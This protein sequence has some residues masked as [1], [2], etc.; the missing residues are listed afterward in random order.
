ML[1]EVGFYWLQSHDVTYCVTCRVKEFKTEV[2]S[3]QNSM[4]ETQIPNIMICF[5]HISI[6]GSI[7]MKQKLEFNVSVSTNQMVFIH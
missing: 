1:S 4:L 5:I 7:Y 3:G 2:E 6:V